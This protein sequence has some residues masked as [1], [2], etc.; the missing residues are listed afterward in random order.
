MERVLIS[1]ILLWVV[2]TIGAQE[3]DISEL[4]LENKTVLLVYGGWAGHQPKKFAQIISEWLRDQDAEVIEST[5]TDVY[6]DK[7]IMGKVD[8]IIQSITMSNLDD[9][10]GS[11]LFKT[12]KNGTGFAGCH[13][14]AGDSFRTSTE[15]Q[16]MLGG[17]FVSHPEG[18]VNYQVNIVDQTEPITKNIENFSVRTEQFYMHV[19]PNIKVLA[20]T[21]FSGEHHYWIKGSIIPVVWKKHY[22]KG[23]VFYSSLGHSPKDITYPESWQILTRGILW[24]AQSKTVEATSLVSPIYANITQ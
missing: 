15:Y 3:K 20:T 10:N 17:Q 7:A 6:S 19:D 24:A 16:Y 8:L 12:I 21:I 2:Q 9:K 14:G 4:T 1:L 22:G 5:S 23:R 13:G 11:G 18:Q